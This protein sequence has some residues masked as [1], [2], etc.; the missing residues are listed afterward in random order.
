MHD[1]LLP[2]QHSV[3]EVACIL[4]MAVLQLCRTG[5]SSLY[6]MDLQ[7]NK[8]IKGASPDLPAHDND[9]I[10]IAV[11]TEDIYVYEDAKEEWWSIAILKPWGEMPLT[12]CTD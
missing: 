5:I 10:G 8:L 3:E 6:M 2:R 4:H 9:M 1:V 11:D 12:V 7:A